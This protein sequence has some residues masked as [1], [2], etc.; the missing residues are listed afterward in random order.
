M[1][2]VSAAG[3]YG[4]V[5]SLTVF[6]PSWTPATTRSMVDGSAPE[7]VVPALKLYRRIFIDR[8]S[9]ATSRCDPARWKAPATDRCA[10]LRAER[11]I[12]VDVRTSC[13]LA[14]IPQHHAHHIGPRL[15]RCD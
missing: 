10:S 4:C 5:E 11:A 9:R 13:F 6:T 7:K 3:L 14:W 8:F 12:D 1:R 2:L 15:H